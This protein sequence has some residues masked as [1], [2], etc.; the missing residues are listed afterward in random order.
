MTRR[1]RVDAAIA[2]VAALVYTVGAADGALG[3]GGAASDHKADAIDRRSSDE[4]PRTDP[5][6]D[7]AV[8]PNDDRVVGRIAGFAVVIPEPSRERSPA[9]QQRDGR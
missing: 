4:T 3:A 5:V 7:R 1:T 2:I 9:A 8:S 6:F